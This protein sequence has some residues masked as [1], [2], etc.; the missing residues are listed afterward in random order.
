MKT[1]VGA[2]NQEKALVGA[3]SV[4]VK[5]SRISVCSSSVAG[6]AVLRNV[7]MLQTMVT[8]DHFLLRS[9]RLCSRC[10]RGES[11]YLYTVSTV[12]SGPVHTP[13]FPPLHYP[14]H[15]VLCT[16]VSSGQLQLE[17]RNSNIDTVMNIWRRYLLGPSTS[18]K[19]PTSIFIL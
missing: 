1:V 7:R 8:A 9:S 2:F 5:S 12:Y 18:W 4:I 15:S 19:A 17:C 3:F 6:A 11:L 16:V 14:L 10:A 13:Y